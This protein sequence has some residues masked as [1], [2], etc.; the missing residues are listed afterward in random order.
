MKKLKEPPAGYQVPPVL[1]LDSD[2][3]M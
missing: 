1:S 2:P 3:T